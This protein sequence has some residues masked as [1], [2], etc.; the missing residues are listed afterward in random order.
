[1]KKTLCILLALLLT[2]LCLPAPAMAR[3][4]DLLMVDAENGA[5]LYDSYDLDEAVPYAV[6]PEGSVALRIATIDW[7]Y[8]VAF[9]NYVGY[10][11]ESDAYPIDSDY[12]DF[13]LPTG[14]N[15]ALDGDIDY[16]EPTDVPEFPYDE[17]NCAGNQKI[18]TR[19]GPN[20]RFTS[21]GSIQ[22]GHEVHVFYQTKNEGVEWAYIEFE[23]DHKLYRVFTPLYRI[24]VDGYLPDDGEDYVWATISAG[25]T[26]RLGPGDEYA[27][28]EHYVPAYTRVKA[29]YQQDGWL[30]YDY[31]VKDDLWQRGW[32]EPGD[33]Y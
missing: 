30:L 25:H 9:G 12:Y 17:M 20:N 18:A 10:I 26:P 23:R 22:V 2:L 7:G 24:N 16:I 6:I 5:I 28:A 33:W 27:S 32:A 15:Y 31:Q 1:M 21:H 29:Y 11:F 3:A 13:E 19:S 8:C 14:E 4:D